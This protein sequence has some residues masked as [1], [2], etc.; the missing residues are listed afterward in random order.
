MYPLAAASQYQIMSA[1]HQDEKE[2]SNYHQWT[3]E[4]LGLFFRN[5]GLGEYADLLVKHKINGHL[6]PLLTDDDLKEMG[7]LVVGDRLMFRHYLKQLSLRVR[8]HKRIASLWEGEERLFFSNC[9]KNCWTMCGFCPLDPSTYKLTTSHLRVKKVRPYR[10]GPMVL[11]CCGASY[12]SHNIDL[13]KVDDVDVMG[14]PAPCLQRVCCCARGKDVLEVE[15]RFDKQP[16]GKV[17][18]RLPEG[19]GEAVSNLILNQV[20]ESQKMERS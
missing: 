14:V 13:S 19:Q 9:E 16:G 10:C 7:V 12:V 6:A 18:L 8:Y 11:C 20:E 17:I 2:I 1:H 5:R 3:P 15:S 4:R